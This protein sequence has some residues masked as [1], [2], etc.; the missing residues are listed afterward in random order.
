M[1]V[2]AMQFSRGSI[3]GAHNRCIASLPGHKTGTGSRRKRIYRS[4]KAEETE[5][6]L[7]GLTRSKEQA[8]FVRVICVAGRVTSV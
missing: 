6:G 4:L 7:R 3:D 5:A 8:R 2:L 1:L